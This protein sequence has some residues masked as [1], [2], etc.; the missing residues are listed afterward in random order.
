MEQSARHIEACYNAVAR[1]YAERFADELG[2]KPLDRELLRR[3]ASEVPGRGQVYDLGCGPGRTTAFLHDCGVSV[4]G[5][6]LWR[7]C[8]AKPG[9]GIPASSLRCG[10]CCRCRSPIR[11]WR[12]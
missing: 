7:S 1:E 8:C 12:G 10:I 9:R 11:R 2:H 3:F 4:R 6:D 5:L